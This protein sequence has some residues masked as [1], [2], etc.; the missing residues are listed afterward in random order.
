MAEGGA[1]NTNLEKQGFVRTEA[2]VKFG[3]LRWPVD[4]H[5]LEASFWKGKRAAIPDLGIGVAAKQQGDD[6]NSK[7]LGVKKRHKPMDL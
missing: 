2:W 3:S 6:Q 7:Y 5:V 1:P 4:L